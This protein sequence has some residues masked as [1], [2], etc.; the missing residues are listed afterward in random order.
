MP[1]GNTTPRKTAKFYRDIVKSGNNANITFYLADIIKKFGEDNSIRFSREVRSNNFNWNHVISGFSIGTYG[2]Y[3]GCVFADIYWQGDSTDGDT[4][5]LVTDILYGKVIPAEWDEV[6]GSW[7]R[8][9]R[10][11]PL[12][13][14]REEVANAFK[15]LGDYIS[16]DAVKARKEAARIAELKKTKKELLEKYAE[17]DYH[18]NTWYGDANEP[19][20]NGKRA[21]DKLIETTPSV[22]ELSNEEFLTIA[23]KVY[24]NNRK[25]TSRLSKDTYGRTTYDLAY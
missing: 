8:V 20:F 21:V 17:K 14:D 18:R 22:L 12:R 25:Y 24:E 11:S 10:H 23:K 4:C 16:L 9:C 1:M 6:G 19:Y 7:G 2:K 3:K 15:A 13:I 5:E